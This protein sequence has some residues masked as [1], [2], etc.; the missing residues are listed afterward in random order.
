M[1]RKL[2]FLTIGALTF[3]FGMPLSASPKFV[4]KPVVSTAE[5]DWKDASFI[6]LRAEGAFLISAKRENGRTTFIQIISEAGGHC[7]LQTESELLEIDTNPGQ[8]TLLG[9]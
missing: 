4:D 2:T 6:N 9:I 1:I 7:R 8:I 5:V 3:F